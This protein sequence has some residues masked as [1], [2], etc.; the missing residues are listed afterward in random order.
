M[1]RIPNLVYAN[2]KGEIF[3]HPELKMAVRSGPY[4]FIPYETELIKLP[5]SSRLY[6]MPYTHPIAYDQKKANLTEFKDGYAVSAF[7]APGFLRLYLPAYKKIKNYTLP[8]FAYTAVGYMDG[9]FVVPALQ[10]DDISKWDPA[11]YDFSPAFEEQVDKFINANPA[12]RIYNQ[13]RKC[14]VEYH[15]TAAKNVFYPRWECPIP[16]SPACNSAC[17]GCISLQA[18]ECC[19][20]PQDRITFA[21]TA[22]EIA[23]VALR[24]GEH[25]PEPLISFGQGCEGDPILAADNIAEAIRI[26]K[27]SNPNLTVN[28]NSNCSVPDN[29]AK[30]ID[31]GADS[32]RVSLNSVIESTYNAYYRPR[33][34][35]FDDVLKSV[36]LMKKSDVFLQL[37]LLT[38]PGVN[39]RTDETDALLNFIEEYEVDLIQT[40]NLNIDAEL[41]SSHLKLGIREMNGIKNMLKMIKKRKPEIQFGYFNRSKKDFYKETGY[42]NLKPLKKGASNI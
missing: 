42:P 13:L 27:K 29:V 21:P 33:T 9:H 6:F 11:N 3:D 22:R 40:R 16:A 28:F 37:N 18:S 36:E 25:A 8:L 19:P 20:S 15:C 38:F 5:P 2:S 35:K 41:L 12:N 17:V 14:A 10:V 7:L 26:I 39:D 24:H 4:D 31:A 34:Y 32:I 30:I 23:E 1:Y